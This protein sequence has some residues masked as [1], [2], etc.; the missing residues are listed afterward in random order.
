MKKDQADMVQ[1]SPTGFL[2]EMTY[3]FFFCLQNI[4]TPCSVERFG[5]KE[6]TDDEPLWNSARSKLTIQYLN[7]RIGPVS[8]AS[9]ALSTCAPLV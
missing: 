5:V 1:I 4:K 3:F 9:V 7:L 8:S 6:K 2:S